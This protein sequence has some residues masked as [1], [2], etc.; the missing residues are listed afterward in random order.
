MAQNGICFETVSDAMPL[1]FI[2][3]KKGRF[4][5]THLRT[6]YADISPKGSS[7]TYYVM[8]EFVEEDGKVKAK[9]Y[10]IYDKSTYF[11]R[12]IAIIL[13]ALITP[14]YLAVLFATHNFNVVSVLLIVLVNILLI[15]YAEMSLNKSRANKEEDLEKMKDEVISRINAIDKWND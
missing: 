11:I 4:W 15:M 13:D 10:S 2:C 3:D 8:G 1:E 6:R 5:I 9:L 14:I 12:R 7:L